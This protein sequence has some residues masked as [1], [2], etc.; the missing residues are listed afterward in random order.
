MKL[1]Y[2]DAVYTASGYK[3]YFTPIFN[4]VRKLYE[5]TFDKAH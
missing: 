4:I 5:Y 1:T 2:N 3:V